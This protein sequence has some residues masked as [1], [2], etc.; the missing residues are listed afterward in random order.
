MFLDSRSVCAFNFFFGLEYKMFLILLYMHKVKSLTWVHFYICR[1][2]RILPFSENHLLTWVSSFCIR[3]YLGSL[4]KLTPANCNLA[5]QW[6]NMKEPCYTRFVEN[7]QVGGM[8]R[9]WRLCLACE[10]LK[11]LIPNRILLSY[12][13]DSFSWCDNDSELQWVVKSDSISVCFHSV[14]NVL[15]SPLLKPLL[16]MTGSRLDW[17]WNHWMD[18]RQK[19]LLKAL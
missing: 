13:F 17:V 2:V 8:L 1:R 6:F 4:S 15:F 11:C 9:K 19:V 3:K 10:M 5:Y 7:K 18:I 12:P 16:E 14:M